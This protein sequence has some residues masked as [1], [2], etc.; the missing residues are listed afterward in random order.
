MS[1]ENSYKTDFETQAAQS[2]TAAWTQADLRLHNILIAQVIFKQPFLSQHPK[3]GMT[4]MF[5]Y[6][7]FPHL[8]GELSKD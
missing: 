7:V 4:T 3:A 1:G 5:R 6:P 8:Q 2:R